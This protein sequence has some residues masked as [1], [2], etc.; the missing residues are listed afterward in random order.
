MPIP[1]SIPVRVCAAAPR[2]L[3]AA[4][5]T[6]VCVVLSATGHAMAACAP[7]PWWTL[8]LG[9]LGVFA[10]AAPLAGR[11]RSTPSVV[12]ALLGGQFILHSLFGLGQRHLTVPP[13]TNDVLI[14][15]AAKLVCGAGPNAIS[16]L[17]AERIIANAGLS[18]AGT[19]AGGAVHQ[20]MAATGAGAGGTA[21]TAGTVDGLLPSLP[22]ILGHLLAALAT[23]WLLRHGDLALLRLTRLSARGISDVAGNAPLRGLRAALLLVRALLAGLPGAT[24]PEPHAPRGF[25]PPPPVGGGETLQHSVI[26]RGPPAVLALA[27]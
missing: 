18:P 12:I 25:D 4:V 21:A 10:V 11:A 7:V 16:P 3:R 5:F 6:A 27:A 2:L 15:M 14:R 26:R 13:G 1:V 23:G 9:F 22:M 20:H 8:L 17:D 24:A 19:M